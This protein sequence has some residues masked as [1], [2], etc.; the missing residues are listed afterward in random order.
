MLDTTGFL[1]GYLKDE[2]DK[3]IDLGRVRRAAAYSLEKERKAR[4]LESARN[5]LNVSRACRRVRADRHPDIEIA[6]I[7]VGALLLTV[8]A[9]FGFMS[10]A[11]A[12]LFTGLDRLGIVRWLAGY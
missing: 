11:L 8:A 2:S 12:G 5:L 7:S 6:N 4:D 9:L 1:S 10:L 3:V